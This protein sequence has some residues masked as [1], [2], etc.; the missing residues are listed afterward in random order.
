MLRPSSSAAPAPASAEAPLASPP[1][2]APPVNRAVLVGVAAAILIVVG[3]GGMALGRWWK[4]APP[5]AEDIG[6][7]SHESANSAFAEARA[8]VRQMK[9]EEALA[10]ISTAVALVPNEPD[11]YCARANIEQTLLQ[12]PAAA[13]DYAKTLH[14]NPEHAQAGANLHVTAEL[15]RANPIEGEAAPNALRM[16]HGAMMQ[17]RRLPDALTIA[18]R[19]GDPQ[20]ILQSASAI[21]EESGIAGS[22]TLTPTGQLELDLSQQKVP[23]LSALR[24]LPIASLKLIR[25]DVAS[26]ACVRDFPLTA[27]DLSRTRVRDLTPLAGMKLR[28]LALDG[29][30]VA[31]LQPLA[32]LPL[33]VLHLWSTP[34]A[35]LAPL[36]GM[37]LRELYAGRTQ[38]KD[39]T[40]LA[41]LPLEV[42][43]LEATPITSLAPLRGMQLH[44]LRIWETAVDDLAPL[45]GMP[46]RKL[47]LHQCPN[48]RDLTPLAH[49]G[50]LARLLIPA[51][52]RE[53]EFLRKM[54][55]LQFIGY[56]KAG[57]DAEALQP[58]AE[59]WA[60]LAKEQPPH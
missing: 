32:G 27:L 36:R 18:E 59:F 52:C 58:A 10:E 49:C 57:A 39:L 51:Q 42:L 43:H 6:A 23:D 5:R 37:P 16:L 1:P 35:D 29:T 34:V 31:D 12:L 48:I 41:G 44:E 30:A 7:A 40:P 11:Y 25:S 56:E 47:L 8:L 21:F 50:E 20:L 38:V 17:Q 46:L 13:R 3:L 19:A 54:P 45:A 2:A 4:S 14:L 26:L 9:F 53:I 33:E 60:K 22:L 28:Q 15:A 55:N 24:G